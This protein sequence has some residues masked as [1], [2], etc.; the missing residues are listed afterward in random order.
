MRRALKLHA[1]TL[2]TRNNTNCEIR[3]GYTLRQLLQL[4]G[5]DEKDFTSTCVQAEAPH[6]IPEEVLSSS[7]EMIH[8]VAFTATLETAEYIARCTNGR[9]TEL[10]IDVD[11]MGKLVDALHHD[12]L[13]AVHVNTVWVEKRKV[14]YGKDTS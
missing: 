2:L 1:E 9:G 8:K 4:W 12:A 5:L 10:I 3:N 7:K 6:A 14:A 13:R 11:M